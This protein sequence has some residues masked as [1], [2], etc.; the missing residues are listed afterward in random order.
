MTDPTSFKI[1]IPDDYFARSAAREYADDAGLALVR[2]FAQNS[3]DAK[4]KNV[5]FIFHPDSE[6]VVSDDG[7][8]ADEKTIRERILTPLATY[9]DE[10]SV[11]GFGKAKEL[12]FFANSKWKIR[13]RDC[14]VVGS[15]LDVVSFKTG[16]EDSPGF[17]VRVTLPDGLYKS[18]KENAYRFLQCS[19][20]PGLKWMLDGEEVTTTVKR[21]KKCSKDFGFAKGYVV[22]GENDPYVYIRTGGLLTTRKYGHQPREVGRIIIEVQ[23]S[24]VDLLTPA[25]D[26]FRLA[27]HRMKVDN[28][29]Y[30]LSTDYRR[31]LAD[32]IGD[33][34][35]FMDDEV[36]AREE[37]GDK[38]QPVSLPARG[39]ITAD[40]SFLQSAEAELDMEGIARNDPD[41][42]D[43]LAKALT[44]EPANDSEKGN[45]SGSVMTA[46][47]KV[48]T[49]KGFDLDLMPKL[50]GVKR[51]TVHTGGKAQAKVGAKWLKSNK[52]F[53]AKMLAALSTGV[54]AVAAAC[55]E[56]VDSV[57]FCFDASTEAEFVRA[58]NGRFA[59][60]LNPLKFNLDDYFAA[61]EL[62]DLIV[63]E[64]A[65]QVA[66]T[67]HDESWAVWEHALRRK[68]RNP[69]IRGAIIRAL[70]SGKLETVE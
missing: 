40:V 67:H 9:K 4:A 58:K 41:A 32:E 62:K 20:R 3:A 12:L 2:E 56:K 19:E 8:G 59:I 47:K 26:S 5:D 65:H 13:T 38:Y 54:R 7:K 36:V 70:E 25:R 45:A 34:I 22:A 18:A 64:M 24:S 63:H 66:G 31:T 33:E 17:L 1:A 43:A 61:D 48:K 10:G 11:G 57:G 28:W 60:L 69:G 46:P 49:E 23:G 42:L 39:G 14:E 29:L 15:Y 52:V 68:C 30:D 51:V 16:L 55:G 27:D 6:L 53:A 50:E 37:E 21:P 35:V 44:G